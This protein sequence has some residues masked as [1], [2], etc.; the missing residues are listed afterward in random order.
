MQVSKTY[1]DKLIFV[2]D[3]PVYPVYPI[4]PIYPILIIVG[5]I[6]A[7]AIYRFK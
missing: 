2:S 6:S 4:Y 5:F 7:W 1:R 3:D